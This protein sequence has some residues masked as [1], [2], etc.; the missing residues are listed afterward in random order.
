[1]M[2][3]AAAYSALIVMVFICQV[4]PAGAQQQSIRFVPDVVGQLG[5]LARRPEALG[6][7]IGSGP[8]P[9]M[10]RHHQG[11]IRTEA[12][13]GTPYF[14]VSRSGPPRDLCQEE[15]TTLGSGDPVGNLYIVRMGSRN[16]HGERL[17]SNR[18]RRDLRTAITPPET[19]DRVVRTIS[20]DGLAKWPPYDHPGG[21]QQVGNI[22]AIGVEFPPLIP[23]PPGCVGPACRMIA[24]PAFAPTLVQF[25]DVSDPEHPELRSTF[26]P[27]EPGA[28]SGVVALT[29]C[30]ADRVGVA[31]ETGHYLLGISG[32]SDN[33]TVHFYESEGDDLGSADLSWNLLSTWTRDELISG[34]WHDHQMLQFLREGSLSGDLYLAGARGGRGLTGGNPDMIDLYSVELQDDGRVRID[35][36]MSIHLNAHPTAEGEAVGPNVADLHAGATFTPS[37][38]LLFYATEH[39]NDGP[40]GSDGRGSVKMGE[41]RHRD[42]VRPGSPTLDPSLAASGPSVVEEGSHVLLRADA[43]P[44]VTTA[45]IELFEHADY[46]GRSVV[47]DYDDWSRDDFDDFKRLDPAHVQ[48][49]NGASDEASSW[50][51]FAPAGCAIRANDDDFGDESFPGPSTLTLSNAGV[52]RRAGD[53]RDV[54][55]GSDSGDM[56]DSITSVEFFSDCDDYYAALMEVDWDLDRDGLLDTAGDVV[57]FAAVEGPE[58]LSIPV[59]AR[60]PI[61]GRSSVDLVRVTVKNVPPSI[62]SFGAFDADGHALGTE[63]FFVIAG[64]PATA[65]SAFSDPGVLDQQSASLDWGDGTV[66]TRFAFFQDALAGR[67]GQL[68]HSHVYPAEGVY[69]I[70]LEVRDDDLGADRAE[71]SLRVL[72]PAQAVGEAIDRLDELIAASAGAQARWLRLAHLALVGDVMGLSSNGAVRKLENAQ[73]AAALAQ[74]WGALG[75]LGRAGDAGA[76]VA[77]LVS[78]VEEVILAVEAGG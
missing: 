44:P 58:E 57:P 50:R 13:D 46:G 30:G 60:H 77:L 4:T 37:G 70:T 33:G 22:L 63:A 23:D 78:W 75:H 67:A 45:W 40:E 29:P 14:I 41:W 53:L 6:F 17:R 21:M 24:D 19:E 5:A 3:R 59:Q 62:D 16:K 12:A 68:I 2:R 15:I 65:R 11:V 76:D 74:L 66:D 64:R 43:A 31:C 72:A 26:P 69:D 51:W 56:N 42:M 7:E 36:R 1:M 48:D 49:T 18:L 9:S 28:K 55:N 20:Y 61:D 32:G 39:D 54:R 10:C 35:E 73:R 47:I 71:L 34:D 38:E 25:V 52:P 8:D 27:T